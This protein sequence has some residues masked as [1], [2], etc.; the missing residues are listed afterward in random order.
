MKNTWIIP[1]AALTLGAVGGFMTGKNTSNDAATASA[2]AEQSMSTRAGNGSRNASSDQSMA[3]RRGS[4]ATSLDDI[5]RAPGNLSRLENLMRFY[6]GL[7]AEQLRDEAAKLD[8]LP[9]NERM[10]ASFLLF[11]RWAEMDPYGAMEYS[12][13]MGMGGAFVRPTIL[14][15]WA[16]VDPEN[17]ARYYTANPGQFALMNVGRMMGAGQDAAS[18]IATEWARQDAQ[19]ALTWANALT[20]GKS[21]ALA[22][23]LGE[24]AKSDPQK[25]AQMLDQLAPGDRAGAYAAIA[26]RYGAQDFGAAEAWIRTLPQ[27]QQSEAYAAAIQGLAA[28]S[29]T[30]ALAQINRMPD[31]DAKNQIIPSLVGPLAR[32]DPKAAAALI[33][34]QS[35]Q[36]VQRDSMRELMP[37]WTAQDPTAALAFARAQEPGPVYDRAMTSYITNNNAGNPAEM[38]RLA[39]TIENERERGWS[40]GFTA[41][42]WMQ[43]DPDAARE[44]IG[45]SEAIPEGMRERILEGRPMWG[46]GRGRGR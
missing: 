41:Q 6:G 42:R 38:M 31:G 26:G 2:D 15:S 9:L 28:K 46:G 33:S 7:S 10:P 24:V 23:V 45:Q 12:N 44:Y 16:S 35:D 32:T 19:G 14:Q 27:D 13:S 30:E 43:S 40:A 3:T 25:A 5:Y 11:A 39:E 20:Q 1:A 29:P 8:E 4:R 34:A 37:V 21:D 17:A 36:D 18:I 22:A